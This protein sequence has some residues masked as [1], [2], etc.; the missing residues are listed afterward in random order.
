MSDWIPVNQPPKESG[1]YLVTIHYV[2][3]DIVEI[4]S[5]ATDLHSV[6]EYDFPKHEAGWYDYSPEYGYY[7]IENNIVAWMPLPE[8]YKGGE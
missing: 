3:Y 6:D 8:S 7:K 4:I 2:T 5:Y 1:R